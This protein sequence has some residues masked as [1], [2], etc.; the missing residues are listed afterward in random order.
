MQNKKCHAEIRIGS[1]VIGIPVHEE[2]ETQLLKHERS[3]K[4]DPLEMARFLRGYLSNRTRDV[5]LKIKDV[6][7]DFSLPAWLADSLEL[8]IDPFI[9]EEDYH[10]DFGQIIRRMIPSDVRPPSEKQLTYAK[11]IAATLGKI[12]TA[13]QISSVSKCS[14]FIDKNLPAFYEKQSGLRAVYAL[15]RKAARGYASF[16]LVTTCGEITEEVLT[17]MDVT[18]KATVEKYLSHFSTYLHEY[19]TM[20]QNIQRI[21]L[22]TINQFLQEHY[23][24]LALPELDE[25]MI[26][27]LSAN[28]EALRR[29]GISS[30]TD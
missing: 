13:E 23:D 18:R 9:P 24:T 30:D 15:S 4:L 29:V 17:V 20:E 5:C 19:L 12:L 22:T 10:D 6:E 2:L 27:W 26:N 16:Y 11:H 7:I 28:P 8:E 1:R 3:L 14:D 21:T 25:E